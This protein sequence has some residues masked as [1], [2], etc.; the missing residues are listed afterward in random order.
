LEGLGK[1][2]AAMGLKTTKEK[3]STISPSRK[4]EEE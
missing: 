4:L 3:A 1:L 2:L